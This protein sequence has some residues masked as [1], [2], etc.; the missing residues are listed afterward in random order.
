VIA[1][2]IAAL[3]AALAFAE[4]TEVGVR[5]P[6]G[7]N[8]IA[9]MRAAEIR[10]P[11]LDGSVDDLARYRDRVVLVNLW[12]TWCVACLSESA[13]L[14]RLAK[15]LD[16][17]RFAVIGVDEGEAAPVVRAFVARHGLTFPVLLDEQQI[18]GRAYAA[19]GLPTT[20]IVDRAGRVSLVNDGPMTLA[21][22]RRAV[23]PLLARP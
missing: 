14:E 12:A 7:T 21:L 19:V 13:D 16:P 22:M 4:R 11:R 17:K 1:G 2:A 18:Y 6:A 9:G 10:L 8:S 23:D 20:V 15:E 5:M 3:V